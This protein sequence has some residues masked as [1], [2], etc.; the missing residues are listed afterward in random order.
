MTNKEMKNVQYLQTS[1]NASQNFTE[2]PPHL[3]QNGY[4]KKTRGKKP[5]NT[6]E[7]AGLGVGKGTLIHC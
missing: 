2:I 1:G 7:N 3:S 4:H 5:T 6:R